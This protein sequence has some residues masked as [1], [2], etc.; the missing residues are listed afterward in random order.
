MPKIVI[1]SLHLFGLWKMNTLIILKIDVYHKLLPSDRMI[2]RHIR[3]QM[4]VL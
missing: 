1:F 2:G 4:Q 3:I